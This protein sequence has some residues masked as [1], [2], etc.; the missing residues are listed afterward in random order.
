L[1]KQCFHQPLAATTLVSLITL[2]Q[3][4]ACGHPA[5][6]EVG[7]ETESDIASL[8]EELSTTSTYLIRG[9]QSGRCL[10]IAGWGTNDGANVQ[11]WDCTSGA[12]QQ[13]R[14][15][16]MGSG[17]YRLRNV[18]SDKCLDVWGWSTANGAD[19]RQY[20]CG[21]GNN[22]Q[23]LV[24]ETS[25]GATFRNR[26]SGKTLDVYA[27]GTGNGSKVVQWDGTGS[28]NQRFSL[29]AVGSSSGSSSTGATCSNESGTNAVMASIAVAMGREMGRWEPLTDLEYGWSGRLQV[30]AAGRARCSDGQCA[31]TAALLSMQTAGSSEVGFP[32][33]TFLDAGV[34]RSRLDAAYNAQMVCESRPDNGYGDDCPSEDHRLTLNGSRPGSCDT[35]FEFGAKSPIGAS[36]L[37]PDQLKNKLLF[38]G[39]PNNPYLDFQSAGDWV[40]IDPTYGLNEVGTTTSGSCTAACTLVS[41]SNRQ[42]Q[43]CSC[44]GRTGSYVRSSFSTSV[45]L[46]K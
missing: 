18:H 25:S 19:V 35:V 20:T 3:A 38:A 4:L 34:F 17:Y 1:S 5:D 28:D 32:G 26:H 44:N 45:Y 11:I 30:S 42:G 43:C 7:D 9:A 13:F 41:T 15:E 21:S 36:L 16:S 29:S 24:N 22:Q 40:S 6:G 23:W 10:D 33:G 27:A 46:C 39:Y 8:S 14:F 37:A 2:T 31:E 12:N